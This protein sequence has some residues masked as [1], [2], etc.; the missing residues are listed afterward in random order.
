M[1]ISRLLLDSSKKREENANLVP[2]VLSL[3]SRDRER[4]LGT[5]LGK[6]LEKRVPVRL[7]EVSAECRFILQ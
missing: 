1:Q 7:T 5:R 4:T 3:L 2:R 6:R